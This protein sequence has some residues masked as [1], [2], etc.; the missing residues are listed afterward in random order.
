LLKIMLGLLPPR[1]GTVTLFGKDIR[2]FSDWQKI[3]YVPQKATGFDAQFPATVEEVVRMGRYGRR[4]LLKD[5]TAQDKEKA[6]E[7]LGRVGMEGERTRLIG[8]LSVGQ[9]Q[10]VFIARALAGEPEI[11]FLDEPTVGVE[12]EVRDDFYALLRTL[13]TNLGLTVVL[14]THDIEA[15]AH[16]AMH[17]ACLDCTLLFHSSVKGFLKD[18]RTTVHT[19]D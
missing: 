11:L 7:A 14:I 8:S 2:Y 17:I 6:L 10:R 4:G 15:V 5:I 18:A 3:G 9:Q 1:S 19:H 12:K 16:E 13:N